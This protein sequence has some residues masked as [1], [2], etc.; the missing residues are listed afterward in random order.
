[1]ERQEAMTEQSPA[2]LNLGPEIEPAPFP[3][4]FSPRKHPNT[5][6]SVPSIPW[7]PPT[8]SPW[9][10]EDCQ[11]LNTDQLAYDTKPSGHHQSALL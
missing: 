8:P 11:S 1:M 4:H 2:D 5:S 10:H 7:L 6:T 3:Q 9:G